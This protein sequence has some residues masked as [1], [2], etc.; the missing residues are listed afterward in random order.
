MV[1]PKLVCSAVFAYR[2]FTTTWVGTSLPSLW[3]ALS[4]GL[5]HFAGTGLGGV[6]LGVALVGALTVIPVYGLA[7]LAWGRTAAG[8]AA[9]M[10][11]ISAVYIHYSDQL[12]SYDLMP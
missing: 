9:F 6:R 2:L 1:M 3:F 11:A 8:L 12:V 4:A 7:R 10:V 5:M